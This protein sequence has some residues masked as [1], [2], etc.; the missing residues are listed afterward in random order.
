MVSSTLKQLLS[1]GKC[2]RC[3]LDRGWVNTGSKFRRSKFDL[4]WQTAGCLIPNIMHILKGQAYFRDNIWLSW[5]HGQSF[6]ILL[7]NRHLAKL[8]EFLWILI[9]CREQCHALSYCGLLHA[10]RSVVQRR[11][12]EIVQLGSCRHVFGGCSWAIKRN[13]LNISKHNK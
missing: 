8:L 3:L 6:L 4:C 12:A 9:G 10:R 11:H 7:K 2:P 13:G 1:R 5:A